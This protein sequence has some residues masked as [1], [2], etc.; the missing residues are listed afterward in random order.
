MAV[1]CLPHKARERSAA[2]NAGTMLFLQ[3]SEEALWGKRGMC[4]VSAKAVASPEGCIQVRG[5]SARKCPEWVV[6]MVMG[7]L[8]GGVRS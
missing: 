3:P 4:L 2:G 7:G 8:S 1:L 6:L 5:Y